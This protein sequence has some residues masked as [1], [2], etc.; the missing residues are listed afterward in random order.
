VQVSWHFRGPLQLKQFAFYSPGSEANKRD[1]KPNIMQRRHG[2]QYFHARDREVVE[3]QETHVVEEKRA[4]GDI[5]EATIDG[6]VVSWTNAYAGPGT[7]FT[8][9]VGAGYPAGPSAAYSAPFSQPSMNAG[10][11]NWSRHAYY[12]AN[13]Q[14]ADGLVFL[15]HNGGQGSGVFDE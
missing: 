14:T 10:S 1:L 5:V 7:A 2:H 8:S 12:N 6:E 15:N 3:I 4:V 11:G 9:V 13:A